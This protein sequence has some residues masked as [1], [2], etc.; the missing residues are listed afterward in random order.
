MKILVV[1]TMT[2]NFGRKNS[3][4]SQEIGLGRGFADLGHEVKIYKS[5]VDISEVGTERLED[6]LIIYYIH[7]LHIGANGFFST[8]RL[9]SSAD[10]L[11]QFADT[12]LSVPLIC[13]WCER[14]EVR[15]IP[16]TGIVWSTSKSTLYAKLVNLLTRRNLEIYRRLGCIAKNRIIA[17]ELAKRG[18][19]KV[20]QAPV[21]IDFQQLYR[22]YEQHDR[23]EL[24]KKWG[25]F[26]ETVL[27]YVGRFNP[28]KR[29]MDLLRVF[30]KIEDK[31]TKLIMVGEGDLHAE[32]EKYVADY[33]LSQRVRFI[34]SIA[35]NKIW[36]LYY[37]SDLFINM[38]YTEIWG[39]SLLE[40]MFYK[41]GIIAA[42]A[43]GPNEMIVNG[44][45][46][47]IFQK[48]EEL[49]SCLNCNHPVTVEMRDAAF[50]RLIENYD[51]RFT[52]A[53]ML[54]NFY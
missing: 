32:A 26:D 35:N 18:V 45:T 10:V 50:R 4:N 15:Y 33:D 37:I 3:Y 36:E 48:D 16:Y 30:T 14:H 12:Q 40:A 27:L 5:V 29:P 39:M 52:A 31:S 23:V 22:E 43:P 11:I 17:A 13:K 21:C 44:E 42:K 19:T 46:G 24:R 7:G 6:N 49:L 53:K 2:N 38:N 47:I 28:S 41:V 25:Y 34:P 9:D 54:E 8:K 51:W 1:V 20:L